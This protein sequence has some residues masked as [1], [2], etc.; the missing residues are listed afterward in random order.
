MDDLTRQLLQ[1]AEQIVIPRDDEIKQLAA[2]ADRLTVLEKRREDQEAAV[3]ETSKEIHLIQTQAMPAS[4][5]AIGMKEFTLLDDRR[6]VVAPQFYAS[7]KDD[8][9]AAAFA[10]LRDRGHGGIIK[11]EMKIDLPKGGDE[12]ANRLEEFV[13][14]ELEMDFERKEFVP[15]QTLGAFVREQNEAAVESGKK[16]DEVIPVQLLGAF[17]LEVAKVKPG[18][19]GKKV[20]KEN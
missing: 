19:A 14:K 6:V 4:M 1:E 12:K 18:R 8:N 20:K 11:N 2:L 15:P 17:V 3:E 10:W 5:R 13:K 7:I 16:L 9:K